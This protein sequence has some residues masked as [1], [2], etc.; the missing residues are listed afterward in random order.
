MCKISSALLCDNVV[1]RFPSSEAMKVASCLSQTNQPTDPLKTALIGEA[2]IATK[3]K[4]F[5]IDN[6]EIN[7]VAVCSVQKEQR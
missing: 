5:Q 7:S 3:C 4:L 1:Q 2:E 6:S